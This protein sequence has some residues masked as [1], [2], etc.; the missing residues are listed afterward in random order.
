MTGQ[1]ADPDVVRI[2]VGCDPRDCDLEQMMVLDYSLRKHASLPLDLRWMR[3]SPSA[4]SPWYSRP[5]TLD[6]WRTQLWATPFSGFRWALPELCGS[7]GRAIYM[8]TDMIALGDIAELWRT[9]MPDAAVVLARKGAPY[10][11]F[12]VSLWDCR[13]ARP[14]LPPL[15]QL[16]QEP[17]SHARCTRYFQRRVNLVSA[18]DPAWNSIDG[19]NQPIDRIRLL[20]YSDMGTQFSH[21]RAMA[22]L[23]AEGRS[24]WF[25]GELLPHPRQ[26]L[27]ALFEQTYAEALASGWRLDDFRN[28]DVFESS[29]VKK[30]ERHH[31]GNPTTRP[32]ENLPRR[33]PFRLLGRRR[34]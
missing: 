15:A 7:E 3:L 25:D 12:C 4:A 31:R 26:D 20:H 18:L 9:P 2:F 13:K 10:T 34:P 17:D 22:R 24:H 30:S 28:P 5:E 27:A 19:E 11:R 33:W 29:V 14:H 21:A 6:G 16:Q 23:A 32:L 1:A 8:D